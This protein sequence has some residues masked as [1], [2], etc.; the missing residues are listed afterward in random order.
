M[1]NLVTGAAGF[2]GS[3]TVDELLGKSQSVR[4][5]VRKPEQAEALR[6]RGAE[7]SV[8]DVRDR[9]AV[10]SAVRGAE[11][12]YHCAAAVGAHYSKEE[13]YA[14]NLDG[15]RNV[16][17][18]LRAAGKGRM[19][20]VSS[21][22]V[23]GIRDFENAT[24]DMPCRRAGEP[25]AD[26]KIDAEQLALDYHRRHGVE[27]TIIRPALIYGPGEKNIPRLL[28]VIRRG[29]FA[30]IGSRDNVIPMVHVG[31]VVQA[32]LLAAA[33]PAAIG[34][35]YHV[36]DGQR[37]TASQFIEY[38]AELIHASPPQKVLPYYVP[39]AACLVFEWLKRL[40]ATKGSGP[41]NRVGLR[42]LGTSR[43]VDIGRAIKELGYSPRV[44]FREGMADTVRWIEEHEHDRPK[45]AG[46]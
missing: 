40:R 41:I 18:A 24:E 20:L 11:V 16:L 15:V 23:L 22:N 26:V 34:R 7:A 25:H 4:G 39:Y 1:T 29:K 21:V 33:A 10:E 17:D 13:I 31:D 2:L 36:T 37:T 35:I 6:Q 44:A 9:G 8:G 19:V 45:A 14:I 32:M 42:F 5:L 38:L 12:V 27:V 28:D 43:S 3:H 30:Y 46:H